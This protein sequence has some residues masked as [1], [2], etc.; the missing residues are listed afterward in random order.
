LSTGQTSCTIAAR[1]SL[2]SPFL[3]LEMLCVRYSPRQRRFGF[4]VIAGELW[5]CSVALN[6]P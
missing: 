1:A 2:Q 5:F 6:P 3:L 4:I